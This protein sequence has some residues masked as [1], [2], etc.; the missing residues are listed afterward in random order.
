[1]SPHW[2]NGDHGYGVVT[3]SLHWLTVVLLATQLLVGYS[4]TRSDDLLEPVVD[5][6]WGGAEG[7]LVL[8][9]VALGGAI[10]I[11]AAARLA[12][13]VTTPLPPWAEGLSAVERR[14]AHRV[15]Q[16]LYASLFL[17]PVTGIGLV[18]LTGEDWDLPGGEWTTPWDLVD[19]DLVLGAHIATHVLL[20][21]AVTVHVGLV[22]KHQLVDRDRLLR[23]ML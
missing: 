11:L 20:Y 14:V 1:M 13:R 22:L 12:W 7:R 5:R 8:V 9:H 2:R 23:R 15:E 4:L 18:T 19:D 21:L 3:K 16:V 10:L 6:L 17:A